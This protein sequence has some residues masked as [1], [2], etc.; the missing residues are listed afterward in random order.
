MFTPHSKW[1]AL[2]T[3]ALL[4]TSSLLA[5]DSGPLL[6]LLVA[7]GIVTDQEAEDLRAELVKDF[8]ANTSAGKLNLSSSLTEFK[9]SGDVRLRHQVETQAPETATGSPIVSN[10]R[11]R[12]RFRFRFNG[13]AILQ[14][15]WGAGFALETAS[16]ADSGNQTFQDANNDYSIFLARAYISYQMSPSL[17]FVAG[18]TKNPFYTSDL[19]WDADINPQ[20][21][22][23]NYKLAIGSKDTFEVRAMQL[24]MDDRNESAI[25][26]AGRDAWLFAQQAVYTHYF[27]KDSLGNQVNN[28]ILAPG[29]MKYNAS[30]ID[31]ADNENP[32]N[33]STRGLAALAFAGEVNWLNIRGA[34]TGLKVYWDSA[35][36]FE[37]N[38]RLRAYG[39]SPT[40]WEDDPLAWL[41]GVG[42]SYGTGK[43]QGDYSLKLDYREIGL[44]SVDP[45]L[46]DSDFAFGKLNQKGFK[47]AISYNLTDFANFNVAYFYT[48]AIQ[49]KLLN[50]IANLDHSQILQ[51]DLVLKF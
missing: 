10:E 4:A 34:G 27:G 36:N 1:L 41:V 13:D 32:F 44:G 48:D 42:Y 30:T 31:G 46:N 14:K 5:Q 3:G 49:D 39:I 26:P 2:L 23:E 38:S 28:L 8:A 11:T 7:K 50:A 16:A 51:L 29:F 37:S 47:A 6:N 24:I 45:N 15:G 22:N 35:Y 25:G 20:G 43:V 12:E 40:A 21:V 9:L 33:G 19:V 17:S 18:K